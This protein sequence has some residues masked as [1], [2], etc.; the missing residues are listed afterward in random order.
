MAVDK[1]A[2]IQIEYSANLAVLLED[3]QA[4]FFFSR[5]AK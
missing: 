4:D 2:P 5:K 3:W 1:R